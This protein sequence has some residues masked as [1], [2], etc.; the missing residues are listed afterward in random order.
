MPGI[1]LL[2]QKIVATFVQFD[3]PGE[4]KSIPIDNAWMRKYS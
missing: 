1:V 2:W 3:L 4:G